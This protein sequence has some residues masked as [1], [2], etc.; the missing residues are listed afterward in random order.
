[1]FAATARSSYIAF[2]RV[3][4]RR[5][6]RPIFATSAQ[7]VAITNFSPFKLKSIQTT[8]AAAMFTTVE[9]GKKNSPA[10]SLYFSKYEKPPESV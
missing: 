7:T 1:M 10:Y 4:G 8:N 3:I 9:K 2:S 6:L 5:L